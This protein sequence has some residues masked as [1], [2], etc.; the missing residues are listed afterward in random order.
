M[1]HNLIIRLGVAAGIV[2]LAGLPGRV[3]RVTQPF[4]PAE[5]ERALTLA[6]TAGCSRTPAAA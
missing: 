4:Q 2:A 3:E 6:L 1:A 5:L